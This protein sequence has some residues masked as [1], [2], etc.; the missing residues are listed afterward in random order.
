MGPAHSPTPMARAGSSKSCALLP[1]QAKQGGTVAE[2]A[3]AARIGYMQER[4]GG[5][6][7]RWEKE[8]LE[9]TSREADAGPVQQDA[10]RALVDNDDLG[11]ITKAWTL[12]VVKKIV[13]GVKAQ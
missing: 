5:D 1:S 8:A 2:Q 6:Y 12:D 9:A 11:P 10:V 13:N 7:R 3:K 4:F